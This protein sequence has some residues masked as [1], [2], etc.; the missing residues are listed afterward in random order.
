[1]WRFGER[2]TKQGLLDAIFTELLK[3]LDQRGLILL[4][5]TIVDASIVQAAR[6]LRK[7]LGSRE[8]LSARKQAQW[9]EEAAFTRKGKGSYYGYKMHIGMD[10]GSGLIRK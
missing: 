7:D 8:A 4:K 9:D 5:G 6:R 1:L 10:A 2:L 3:E